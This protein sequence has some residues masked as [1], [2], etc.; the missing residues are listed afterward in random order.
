[1]NKLRQLL[2]FFILTFCVVCISNTAFGQ[3]EPVDGGGES[4]DSKR[5]F[6][7]KKKKVERAP[8]EWYKIISYEKDTTYLD[9]T[10]S[11]KKHYK[12]NYL[13][14]DNFERQHF[15]NTGRPYLELAKQRYH[16]N[17]IPHFGAKARHAAYLEK[18]DINYYHVPTP[19]SDLYY[20][21]AFEQGQNLNVFFTTNTSRSLNLS[22]G[23]QGERS[24]GKYRNQLTSTKAFRGTLSYQHPSR[25]YVA[26]LHFTDQRILNQ[27]NGGLD[28]GSLEQFTSGDQEFSDRGTLDVNYE[29]AENELDGRRFHLDH[30]FR[31]RV[32]DTISSNQ[33]AVGHT[34][35]SENKQFKFNQQS[36]LPEFFG[37]AQNTDDFS[38]RRTL[39]SYTNSLYLDWSNKYIGNLRGFVKY[40]DFNYFY[41]SIYVFSDADRALG[42]VIP[43]SIKDE[44]I[45]FGGTYSNYYKGFLLKGD[46]E[47][48]LS[49]DLQNQKIK[50]TAGYK[51]N[52]RWN[53]DFGYQLTSEAPG[54]NY[55]LHQSNYIAYN[56]F[57]D[58]DNE[59]RNTFTANL[60][61]KGLVNFNV[62]YSIISNYLFFSRRDVQ[63]EVDITTTGSSV[64]VEDTVPITVSS[65]SQLEDAIQVL[66]VKANNTVRFRKWSL[67]N[68]LQF[69]NVGGSGTSNYNVPSFITRN[70]LYFSSEVFKRAMFLQTGFTF[71]YYTEYNADGYD[72]LIG[73]FYVQNDAKFGGSP[74]LDFFL[75]AKVR[76]TRIFFTLENFQSIFKTNTE[77]LT[78]NYGTRDF[79]VRFGLVWNF[80]L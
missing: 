80:F 76:Q 27:E 54:F 6:S 28:E 65:P 25:K 39:E 51:I 20:R 50:A 58:F 13:R 3:E 16:F 73:E 69:Q 48:S 44:V 49:G 79:T 33:I 37:E 52:D 18:Q 35:T 29:N 14:K 19:L 45:S 64:V 12:F 68:T 21:S 40:T 75:N 59:V 23:Y 17:A 42:T 5:K 9:T 61:A 24:L 71:K 36:A 55:Q 56:W 38:D 53:F 4:G 57:T 67:D 62:D 7:Q 26:N 34:Y 1:M 11:I 70:S 78:T 43:A 63:T 72:P 30:Q 8:I 60:R 32:R 10:L 66:K 46:V 31:L 22:I 77:L 41:K 47:S 15:V 2:H 74:F